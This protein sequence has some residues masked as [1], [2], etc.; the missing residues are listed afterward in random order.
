MKTSTE[1]KAA[2]QANIFLSLVFIVDKQ[3]ELEEWKEAHDN[4]YTVIIETIWAE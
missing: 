4:V 3:S 1:I 2:M